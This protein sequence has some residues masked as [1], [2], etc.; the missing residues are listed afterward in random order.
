MSDQDDRESLIQH[1][2]REIARCQRLLATLL[3]QKTT[4]RLRRYL[5]DLE[6]VRGQLKVSSDEAER[7]SLPR[8]V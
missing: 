3:D 1:V 8:D 6:A 5:H 7:E 2:E 4:E